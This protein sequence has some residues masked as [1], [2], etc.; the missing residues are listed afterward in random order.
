MSNDVASAVS[1]SLAWVTCDG[2]GD[3]G[4]GGDHDA[5]CATITAETR[6]TIIAL[7]RNSSLLGRPRF[8]A[9]A[10]AAAAYSAE[11]DCS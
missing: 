3:D 8:F 5:N 7:R 4:G 1:G 11:A 6:I 10:A 9:S 2:V